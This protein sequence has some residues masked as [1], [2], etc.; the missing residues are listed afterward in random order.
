MNRIFNNY[1]SWEDAKNGLYNNFSG[2][3]KEAIDK[4]LNIF[5]NYSETERLMLKFLELW[6]NSCDFNL[7][8]SSMNRIAWLGQACCNIEDGFSEDIVRVAWS[9]VPEV[10][11]EQA[12]NIAKRIISLWEVENAKKIF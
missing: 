6:E 1:A 11:Q 3:K 10:F 7:S 8:N 12:N 2:N 9:Y 5:C 4:I